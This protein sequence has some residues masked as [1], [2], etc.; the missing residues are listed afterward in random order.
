MIHTHYNFDGYRWV[1]CSVQHCRLHVAR[2]WALCGFNKLKTGFFFSALYYGVLHA[3]SKYRVFVVTA[4]KLIRHFARGRDGAAARG[5]GLQSTRGIL[6]E[7]CTSALIKFLHPLDNIDFLS[8]CRKFNSILPPFYV[9]PPRRAPS[10]NRESKISGRMTPRRGC[11]RRGNGPC[12]P[13]GRGG[14]IFL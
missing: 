1:L 2:I 12:R 9:A 14:D 5:G 10:A 4:L 13:G 11:G 3:T 6:I 8:V 7:R